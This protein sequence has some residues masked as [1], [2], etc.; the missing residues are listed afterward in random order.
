MGTVNVDQ[1][2]AEV[3][4]ADLVAKY[5]QL[6]KDGR[7]YV[8]LCPVH[9]E[10]RPSFHVVPEKGFVHCFSCGFHEDAI[11][12]VMELEK[13]TF[14]EACDI[15]TGGQA[16]SAPRGERKA[17]PPPV[18]IYEGFDPQPIDAED[19]AV[20]QVGKRTPAILNPKRADDP[21]R[22]EG[23]FSPVLVHWYRDPDGAAIGAVLRHDFGDGRKE[24]PQ[25]QWVR[26]PDGAYRWARVPFREPRPLYG[27]EL[28]AARPSAPV[29]VVEGEKAADRARSLLPSYVVITWPGGSN[30]YAKVDW[31]PLKGRRVL[32]WPDADQAGVRAMRG[33]TRENGDAVR[34]IAHILLEDVGVAEL[35]VI[36]HDLE[37]AEVPKGWDLADAA[38]DGWDTARVIA[39]AKPRAEVITFEPAAPPAQEPPP[40]PRGE[41]PPYEGGYEPPADRGEDPPSPAPYEKVGAGHFRCLG[42]DDGIYFFHPAGAGQVVDLTPS[43]I[44]LPNLQQFAPLQWWEQL[45]PKGKGGVDTDSARDAMINACHAAGVFDPDAVRGRG[46][47]EDS[48]RCI[49][50][51]G[52]KLIVDGALA[53]LKEFDT[54]YVY[55]RR[56]AMGLTPAVPATNAQAIKLVELLRKINRFEEKRMADLLAGWLFVAPVCGAMIWRSHLWIIGGHG[57]GKSWVMDDVVGRYLEGLA[58]RTQGKSTEASIRQQVKGDAVP[59]VFDEAE[60]EDAKAR[61][62]IQGVL[63]L[64]RQASS[65]KGAPIH[66]GTSDGRGAAYRMRVTFCFSSINLS[67]Q[68]MAD[69]SRIVQ[70]RMQVPQFECSDE[71]EA[72]IEAFKRIEREHA[73]LFTDEW[74]ASMIARAVSMIPVL[75]ANHRTFA[76]VA[77]IRFG[78]RRLGD[79]LGMMLAGLYGLHSTK[80]ISEEKAADFINRQSWDEQEQLAT[81][82][83]EQRLL[84]FLLES[85]MRV[86]VHGRTLT[87]NVGELAKVVER[88]VLE[89]EGEPV[90]AVVARDHL[91][92][93]GFDVYSS[94]LYI[95]NKHSW[96]AR[97]LADT[98]W[99]TKWHE[100]LGR[101]PGAIKQKN[102]RF[103]TGQ[104]KSTGIPMGEI[105]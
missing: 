33:W 18:D 93:R 42:F 22:A 95:S 47:W 1:V 79:T 13:C 37:A 86:E 46:A 87:R 102:V 32:L 101:L 80:E 63:D 51:L 41:A 7:E 5:V 66:K 35:K 73:E 10:K 61:E 97:R 91:R 94:T 71:R 25:I 40:E 105:G 59:I 74:R 45:Y 90:N 98:A 85:E 92:R 68:H 52:D 27:L 24:T 30:G 76:K 64:A 96:I 99:A 39:W 9:N 8:G 81:D 11:G 43:A 60:A 29:L 83:S 4:L 62:R 19:E 57:S 84:S 3:N 69:E 28:L 36:R 55:E 44:T 12:F 16:P 82:S 78:S 20:F 58:F 100:T 75:R 56:R 31:S 14:R 65:P 15:I 49:L 2:L 23:A 50:H 26:C 89:M 54:R 6:T 77:A 48:G 103:P 70:V 21:K 34:G 104:E 53:G 17:L 72:D 38:A 67:L 88:G